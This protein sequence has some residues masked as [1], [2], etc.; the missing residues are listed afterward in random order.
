[1]GLGNCPNCWDRVCSCNNKP[2]K[3][4]IDMDEFEEL[5]REYGDARVLPVGLSSRRESLD[6]AYNT[7][8]NYIQERI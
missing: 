7:I 2:C 5:L 1:M 8:I 6:A 4:K 3:P